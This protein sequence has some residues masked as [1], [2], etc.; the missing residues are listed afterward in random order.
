MRYRVCK[1]WDTPEKIAIVVVP[2]RFSM[3]MRETAMLPVFSQ[4]NLPVVK[5]YD[6]KK[7]P[8]YRALN[9]AEGG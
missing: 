3:V 9:N 7:T 8:V 1:R 4:S 6:D 2:Y 5:P